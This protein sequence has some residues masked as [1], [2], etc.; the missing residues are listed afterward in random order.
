MHGTSG[1]GRV[2]PLGMTQ[3]STTVV[4]EPCVHRPLSPRMTGVLPPR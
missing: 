1:H 4:V 2:V 3:G